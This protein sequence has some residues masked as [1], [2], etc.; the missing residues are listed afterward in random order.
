MQAYK[1]NKL[2]IDLKIDNYK[3]VGCYKVELSQKE[4][5]HLL[6][7]IDRLERTIDALNLENSKK[8]LLMKIS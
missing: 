1:R 7:K 8:R 2:G 3:D 5:A 4:Y 6:D